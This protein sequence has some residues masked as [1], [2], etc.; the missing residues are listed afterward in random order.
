MQFGI[1]FFDSSVDRESCP[2]NLA[3]TTSTSVALA[4]G[5]ALAA[6]WI[7]R[8]KI[9][10][11]DF[12]TNHPAGNLGKKLTVRTKDLMIPINKLKNLS[13]E[14]G[15]TQI[16]EYLTRDGIELAAFLMNQIQKI[17]WPYHRWGSKK[18]S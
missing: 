17:N 13:P 16:I 9:S 4:I 11:V 6:V 8:E 2:L 15:I 18:S 7:E 3:P 14:M 12:V 5:D 10:K 1:L